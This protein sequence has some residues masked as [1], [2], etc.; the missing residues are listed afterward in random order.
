MSGY[1]SLTLRSHSVPQS[2]VDSFVKPTENARDWFGS[3]FIKVQQT[4]ID[5]GIFGSK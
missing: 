5:P 1:P 2:S 4:I 3:L